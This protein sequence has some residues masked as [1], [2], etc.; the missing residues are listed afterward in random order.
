MCPRLARR[1]LC[2]LFPSTWERSLGT[3]GTREAKPRATSHEPEGA[4]AQATE[5]RASVPRP[6]AAG[7]CSLFVSLVCYGSWVPEPCNC[8]RLFCSQAPGS[9]HS[10]DDL[11]QA[12]HALPTCEPKQPAAG[13]GSA[14]RERA[15]PSSEAGR[16]RVF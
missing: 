10:Q 5:S 15:G 2:L 14:W 1:H 13:A 8:P 12:G 7:L 6:A 9:V 16:R 4:I 11:L 3:R